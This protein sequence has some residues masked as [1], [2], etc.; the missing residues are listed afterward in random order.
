MLAF[1]TSL[2]S[3]KK[4]TED[5]SKKIVSIMSFEGDK[6]EELKKT[7]KLY[8]LNGGK[9]EAILGIKELKKTNELHRIL[10]KVAF[11]LLV[12]EMKTP[13]IN[14]APADVLIHFDMYLKLVKEGLKV[15]F[16]EFYKNTEDYLN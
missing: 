9:K 1:K 13:F 3:A 7:T 11:S 2:F 5:Q 8:F 10:L 12:A 14:K 4:E 15:S 6:L 16:V